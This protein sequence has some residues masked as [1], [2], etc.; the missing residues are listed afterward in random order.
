MRW[1]ETADMDAEDEQSDTNVKKESQIEGDH[2]KYK[3][4]QRG[5]NR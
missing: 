5:V 4:A 3:T 2:W 1:G